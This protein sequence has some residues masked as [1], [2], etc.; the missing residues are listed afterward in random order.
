MRRFEDDNI[1]VIVNLAT[2]CNYVDIF[3]QVKIV[4]LHNPSSKMVMSHGEPALS[5][6]EIY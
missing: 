1:E 4:Q 3:I 5:I 6:F 2:M